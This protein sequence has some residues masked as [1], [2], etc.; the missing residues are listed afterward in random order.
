MTNQLAHLIIGCSFLFI[1]TNGFATS[2]AKSKSTSSTRPVLEVHQGNYFRWSAPQGW[3]MHETTNGVDLASPDGKTLV[4][5]ALLVGSYGRMT[6]RNFLNM[7][8][9]QIN[10]TAKVV[11]SKPLP[12][13]PGLMGTFWKIE[14]FSVTANTKGAPVQMVITVGVSEAYGR[15]SAT[16][17]L[18]QAP[19]SS[20]QQ[21]KTWLPAITQ[22]IVVTNPRQLAGQDKVTLPRN[23]PLDN[24]G[25]IESWRRKGMSEDRIS[26][27]RR[28][29]MMGYTRMEDPQTGRKYNMPLETYD[30]T[31]GGYRNPKRPTELLRKAPTGE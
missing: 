9:R 24:S 12:N 11:G 13:Q 28:E 15:Y 7:M 20:W 30:G 1:S 4:S 22:S 26:Q 21:D 8:L 3:F 23:N 29:G 18:Y 5:S 16:M 17:T 25:L 6:P 14:E 31:V 27:A 2:P 19:V 10:P